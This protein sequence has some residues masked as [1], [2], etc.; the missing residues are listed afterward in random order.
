ME[1]RLNESGIYLKKVNLKRVEC[2]H[3]C[4]NAVEIYHYVRL[5]ENGG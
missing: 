5:Y 1:N 4:Q 2:S 3:R